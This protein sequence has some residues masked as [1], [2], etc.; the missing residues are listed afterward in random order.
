M[1]ERKMNIKEIFEHEGLE[2]TPANIQKL[3][4]KYTFYVVDGMITTSPVNNHIKR[5]AKESID[6]VTVDYALLDG[7]Y[8]KDIVLN[9]RHIKSAY[10]LSGGPGND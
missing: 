8:I 4:D 10:C 6:F 2:P 3:K 9:I 7:V 5:A 1:I